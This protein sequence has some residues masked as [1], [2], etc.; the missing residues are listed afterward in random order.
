M[1]FYMYRAQSDAEYPPENINAADLPGV[2]WYLH[3]EIVGS[4]PRKYGITRILRFKITMWNTREL[5][6][7][8][9]S[10][11]GP[12]VAFD[13]AKCTVPGCDNLW[14]KY[15]FV[16][17]CQHLDVGLTTYGGSWYSLPGPCPSQSYAAPKSQQCISLN[18]G[19]ACA[20]PAGNRSCTFH[21]EPAGDIRLDELVGI[22]DYEAFRAAG[23]MEYSV[24]ADRGRHLSF[25]DGKGNGTKCAWR[26]RQ[27]QALFQKHHPEASESLPEPPCA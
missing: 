1:S 16:V 19:G 2:M 26:V 25:W 15:G 22:Q 18:P 14:Q 27:A 23:G 7:A 4:T 6:R 9:R 11:F 12:F 24:S 8:T 17:G 3:N 5:F 20:S 21:A 13:S 10:Q